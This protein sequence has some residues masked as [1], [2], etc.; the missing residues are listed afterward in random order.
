MGPSEPNITEIELGAEATAG[1]KLRDD[2]PEAHNKG[3]YNLHEVG[4]GW[5]DFSGLGGCEEEPH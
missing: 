3:R 1:I 5:A 2:H 4:A